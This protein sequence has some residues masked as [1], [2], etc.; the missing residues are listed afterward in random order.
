MSPDTDRGAV[1]A[2]KLRN[3]LS[4]LNQSTNQYGATVQIEP[5]PLQASSSNPLISAMSLHFWSLGI[6]S[7]LTASVQLF[8][9]STLG[10]FPFN[11][12]IWLYIPC[13][14]LSYLSLVSITDPY[15]LVRILP[16]S[17]FQKC[18]IGLPWDLFLPIN[19]SINLYINQSINMA[20][21]SI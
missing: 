1:Q 21:N 10:S 8:P 13:R 18:F 7:L 6:F 16:D 2:L 19:Q 17:V 4:I 9:R 15:Q 14:A 3:L 5:W 11:Q 12:S 20:L